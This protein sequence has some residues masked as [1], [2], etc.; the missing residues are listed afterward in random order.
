MGRVVD[1]SQC[2]P[3]NCG[4]A[5]FRFLYPQYDFLG[6]LTSATNAAGVTFS[7]SYNT[8]GRLT[9]ISTNFIDPSHPGTL[10]SNATY[11]PPGLLTSVR[12]GNNNSRLW[13]TSLAAGSAYSL[14]VTSYAP[15]GSVL[16]ANDSANGNWTY[17]YD[18]F[19]RLLTSNATGQPYTYAYDRFGNRWQQNGPYSSQLGFD[20][21]N[22]ITAVT[23]V[24]YDASGNLTG[25]A[26]QCQGAN[27][28]DG[29]PRAS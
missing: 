2:T 1:N 6:N 14:S 28:S 23:G 26:S 13:L 27:P 16:T 8:A 3:Q 21:N 20:A 7:Y 18:P 12:L 19:N 15:N 10:F 22:R 5:T 4:T 11:N 17:T 24:G 25:A 29:D 9:G